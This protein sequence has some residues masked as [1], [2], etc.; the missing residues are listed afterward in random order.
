VILVNFLTGGYSFQSVFESDGSMRKD[1][2]AFVERPHQYLTDADDDLCSLLQGMLASKLESRFDI[3]QILSHP[4]TL[5]APIASALETQKELL[6]TRKL[7]STKDS[8]DGE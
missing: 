2:Q 6:I 5:K 3:A 7:E 8:P 4:W 1:Y